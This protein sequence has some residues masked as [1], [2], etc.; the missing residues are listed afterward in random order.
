MERQRRVERESEVI[1]LEKKGDKNF[2]EE[3]LERSKSMNESSNRAITDGMNLIF[4]KMKEL[5]KRNDETLK[6]QIEEIKRR[7]EN[8]SRRKSST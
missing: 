3:I 1:S 4:A 2:L 8:D 6:K 5:E 7:V